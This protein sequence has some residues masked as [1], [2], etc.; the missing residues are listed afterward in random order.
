ME[1]VVTLSE[2]L[3]IGM[4]RQDVEGFQGY[5][6]NTLN[7]SVPYDDCEEM[8]HDLWV[9]AL[10]SRDQMDREADDYMEGLGEPDPDRHRDD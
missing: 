1:M 2:R 5:L 6:E 7:V 4:F 8:V 3:L 9:A 10:P